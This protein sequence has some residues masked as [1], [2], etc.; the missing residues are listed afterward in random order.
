VPTYTAAQVRSIQIALNNAMPDVVPLVVDG[1]YGTQTMA[2]VMELQRREG[3]P[4]T[5]YLDIDTTP[6]ALALA[7]GIN[8]NSL[9][10][11][12]LAT[13]Q[14]GVFSPQATGAQAGA[15]FGTATN[16]PS[17]LPPQPKQQGI[18]WLTIAILGLLAVYVMKD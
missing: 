10:L 8:L 4:I 18:S 1:V 11:A 9:L 17:N 13:Q 7:L 2:H 15:V 12:Q 6:N 14:G 3:L 5:G 16:N